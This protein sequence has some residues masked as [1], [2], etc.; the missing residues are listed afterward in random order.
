MTR[1]QNRLEIAMRLL[2]G[3]LT[4]PPMDGYDPMGFYHKRLRGRIAAALYMADELITQNASFGKPTTTTH[5]ED[6][7]AEEL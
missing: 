1:D 2:D 6:Y 5:E 3:Q 7:S 4:E